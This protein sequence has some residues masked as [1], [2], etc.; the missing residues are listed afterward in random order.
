[1][2][3][4]NWEQ[5]FIYISIYRYH[6]FKANLINAC[7]LTVFFSFFAFSFCYPLFNSEISS[8]ALNA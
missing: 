2:I 4:K 1:M 7:I 5:A 6:R 8:K 3:Y